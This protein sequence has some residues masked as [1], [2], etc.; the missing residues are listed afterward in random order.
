MQSYTPGETAE[1]FLAKVH[2]MAIPLGYNEIQVRDKFL[3]SLPNACR[4]S[5][6]MTTNPDANLQI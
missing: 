2:K 1:S 5:V 3:E 4:S 6:L